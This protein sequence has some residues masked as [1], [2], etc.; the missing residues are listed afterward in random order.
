MSNPLP[1]LKFC[2][3]IMLNNYPSY[4]MMGWDGGKG[5]ILANINESK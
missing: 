5:L 4:V 2:D 3:Y 1:I